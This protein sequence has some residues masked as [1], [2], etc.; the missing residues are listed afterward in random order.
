MIT[1]YPTR[2][3]SA[4]L[5]GEP[6][7]PPSPRPPA[8]GSW[9]Y[10][11][12]RRRSRTIITIAAL[13]S[14]AVHAGLLFGS[15]HA[16][17]KIAAPKAKNEIAIAFIVPQIKELEEPEPVTD[18][19]GEKP[20]ADSMP[21]PMQADVPQLPRPNDFVQQLDFA[22][23]TM[24]QP[25]LSQSKL[26]VIPEHIR[27]GG[28]TAENF[29]TIFNLADLD[30]HPEPI[31]QPAPVYP[32]SMLHEGADGVVTVE[33][34]VDS[35]G[36]VLNAFAYES[37][38]RGFDDAAIV[39]VKRWKFHAGMRGGRKVNTRMRVPIIFTYKDKGAN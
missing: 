34:I 31:V 33:F 3:G 38:H 10:Q 25:D 28:K 29:G 7:P 26:L 17:K 22:S 11:C 24:E 13:L 4:A 36:R 27:R 16:K 14:V 30:R 15:G 5:A 8:T 32:R 12:V 20:D 1:H 18:E 37:S 2:L 9:R 19:A 21:V 39:G 35:Q 6:A 23:L